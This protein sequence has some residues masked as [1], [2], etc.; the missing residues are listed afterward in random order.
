MGVEVR[1]RQGLRLFVRPGTFIN[2][3]QWS[4]HHWLMLLSFLIIAAIESHVGRNQF[5]YELY[6][7]LLS[8]RLGISWEQGL[9][10]V[11]AIKLGVMLLGAFALAGSIWLIGNLFGRRTSRRVLFRRLSIVFTVLLAGYTVQHSS[12][13]HPA[14]PF[15]TVALYLWGAV[16]GY[17]AIREQFALSHLEATVLGA[18]ALLLISSVWHYS[19]HYMRDYAKSQLAYVKSKR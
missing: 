6:S 4:T 13:I 14:V 7:T 10:L 15:F 11:T 5:Y 8:R 9:W 16:L 12:F 19:N 18:F 17:F 2:Q 1:M 3:L